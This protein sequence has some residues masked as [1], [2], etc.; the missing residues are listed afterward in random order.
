M[1]ITQAVRDDDQGEAT[2]KAFERYR[3]SLMPFIKKQVQEEDERVKLALHKEAT[4]GPL[5]VTPIKSETQ[6]RSQLRARVSK[7]KSIP[8]AGI[9]RI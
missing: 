2:Q 7:L 9:E 1:T 5:Q 3:D 6:A 8:V 4:R